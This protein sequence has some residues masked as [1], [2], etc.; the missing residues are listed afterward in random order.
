MIKTKQFVPILLNDK[1][2]TWIYE[3]GEPEITIQLAM[4][5]YVEPVG[6]VPQILDVHFIRRRRMMPALHRDRLNLDSFSGGIQTG[7]IYYTCENKNVRFESE[8]LPII[9]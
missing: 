2:V 9:M 4:K 1:V 8:S 3:N 6:S 7:E 5:H